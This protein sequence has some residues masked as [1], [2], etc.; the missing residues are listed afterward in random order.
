MGLALQAI[1]ILTTRECRRSVDMIDI[2]RL[3]A[4]NPYIR[5]PR[6]GR[7]RLDLR[8]DELDDAAEDLAVC[9]DGDD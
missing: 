1:D 7:R 9:G 8:R 4:H 6:R 3:P 5:R 2:D